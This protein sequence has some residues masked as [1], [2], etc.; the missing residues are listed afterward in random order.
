MPARAVAW[1]VCRLRPHK[2]GLYVSF[3]KLQHALMQLTVV[4]VAQH[5]VIARLGVKVTRD[6]LGWASKLCL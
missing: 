2:S 6:L 5:F 3:S 4:P 1:R